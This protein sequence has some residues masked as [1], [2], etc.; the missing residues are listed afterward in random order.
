MPLPPPAP[1]KHLHT[2]QV[3]CQGL[4]VLASKR[5]ETPPRKHGNLPL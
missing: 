2:R 5:Q 4:E 3:I 1:R